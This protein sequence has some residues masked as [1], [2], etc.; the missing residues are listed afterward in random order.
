[1]QQHIEEREEVNQGCPHSIETESCIEG[2]FIELP[3]QEVL[4]EK[5]A[6]TITQQPRLE[7][8]EV[9]AINK[10]TKKRM[11][12]K[13][14]RTI[15]VKKRGSKNNLTPAPTS[16]FTQAN[17][18]RKLVG[19]YSKQGTLTGSSF[20]LRSFLLTNW[21]KRKKVENNMSS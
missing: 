5:D 14:R 2:E 16:K 3:I 20:L 15:S 10:S 1:M 4:D 7:I 12:T 13:K 9:K 18:K 17:N 11:V 8:K 19:M 6:P 21:K